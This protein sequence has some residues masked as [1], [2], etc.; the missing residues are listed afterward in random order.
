MGTKTISIMDDVYE[1]LVRNKRESES[2][3]DEL[4]RLLNNGGSILEC[5]GLWS[6]LTDEQLKQMEDALKRSKE[7]TRKHIMERL[8]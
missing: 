4:R 5:A 2:F 3:S 8:K 7:Y 6:D 1:L